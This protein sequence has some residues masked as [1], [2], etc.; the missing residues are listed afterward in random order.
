MGMELW[1]DMLPHTITVEPFTGTDVFGGYTY[2]AAQTYSARVQGRTRLVTT[3]EGEEKTSNVTIY[4]SGSGIGPQDRVTLPVQFQP[5]QPP[6][7]S[8]QLVSDES[9]HHHTVILA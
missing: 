3:R 2:G 9:G 8:V 6:I 4:V 1:A 7:L 5:T